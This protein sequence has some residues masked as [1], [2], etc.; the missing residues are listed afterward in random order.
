MFSS[1]GGE[2]LNL[3]LWFLLA[4]Y[5]VTVTAGLAAA[6][7]RPMWIAIT[8]FALSGLAMPLGW[9]LTIGSGILSL[10]Y[11]LAGVLYVS[12]V[13]KK[14]NQQI[15]FSVQ[16]VAKSQGLLRM[17]LV[18]IACGSLYLGCAA[19]IE[20]EGFSIPEPYLKIASDQIEERIIKPKVPEWQ[21]QEAAAGFREEF[22]HAVDN[23]SENTIKPY[24]RFIPLAIVAVLFTPLITIVSLLAWIP[25]MLLRI[26]FPLLKISGI[27]KIVSET[28]EV[29]RLTID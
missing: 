20:Q 17:A 12:A 25:A 24:E 3:L 4:L 1:S 6:L 13:T 22:K 9:Q 10:V 26:I 15:E 28:K 5:V 11:L 21:Y 29:Q 8:A 27:T 2:L 14:L 19:H 18:L 7:L 23:F 16:P